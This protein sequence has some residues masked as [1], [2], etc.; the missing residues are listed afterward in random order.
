MY[1]STPLLKLVTPDW[2]ATWTSKEIAEEIPGFEFKG[3]GWYSKQGSWMLIIN[4]DTPDVYTLQAFYDR[5]P[6]SG[7][8]AISEAPIRVH[9]EPSAK[10]EPI[11]YGGLVV[12]VIGLFVFLPLSGFLIHRFGGWGTVMS[13]GFVF[14]WWRV[15]KWLSHRTKKPEEEKKT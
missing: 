1:S 15:S 11:Q 8:A 7:Y 4:T 2:Q 5:D 6:R 10:T 13:V 12:L 14:M 3:A 9:D